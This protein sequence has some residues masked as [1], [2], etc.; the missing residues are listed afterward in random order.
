MATDKTHKEKRYKKKNTRL[1]VAE[2]TNTNCAERPLVN[3]DT[4]RLTDHI[5]KNK[6]LPIN[7]CFLVLMQINDTYKLSAKRHKK[8]AS[9]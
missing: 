2:G 9:V 7:Q 6:K 3:D 4:R 1:F 5:T 8:A